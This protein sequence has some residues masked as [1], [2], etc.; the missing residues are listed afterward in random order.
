MKEQI[1]DKDGMR[2]NEQSAE[3][4]KTWE[5]RNAVRIFFVECAHTLQEW[6]DAGGCGLAHA[7][8]AE[9]CRHFQTNLG[10]LLKM[11]IDEIVNGTDSGCE[12]ALRTFVRF[13]SEN[14]DQLRGWAA[15]DAVKSLH[16]YPIDEEGFE[17]EVK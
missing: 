17:V 7:T 13:K 15:L 10:G 16:D 3:W 8:E 2:T 4:H 12:H 9:L 5:A 11:P 6:I 14:A 1:F